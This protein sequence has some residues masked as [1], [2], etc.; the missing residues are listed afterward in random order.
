MKMNT[1][2]SLLSCAL[3]AMTFISF[4]S[5]SSDVI[6][7]S[8]VS[9][10]GQ[11]KV[12]FGF[13]KNAET[14]GL[15]ASTA[16]PT[17]SWGKN[18]KQLMILFVDNSSGQVKAARNITVP[19]EDNLDQKTTVLQNI[20]AGSFEA[21]LIANYNEANLKR[22][23]IAG[24]WNEGNVV[25]KNIN[26]LTLQLVTNDVFNPTSTESSTTAY[27]NPSEVF[28]AKQSVNVQADQSTTAPTFSL[29]RIIS[30]LRV[31][32]DQSQNGNNVVDFGHANADLRV[33]KVVNAFNPK[34]NF[35]GFAATNTIYSKGI[36]V[37]KKE[38]PS[39]GYKGGLILDQSNHITLWSDAYIFPGGSKTVGDQKLDIVLG[40]MAPEGYVPLGQTTGLR[41]PTMVYWSGQVQ[42]AVTSN[43]IL[44]V[45]CILKQAGSTE[46]PEIGSYGNLDLTINL[47]EW[48]NISSTN[49]EM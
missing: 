42:N 5:C 20:P 49:I 8:D 24:L 15:T 25:G 44:E 45:N 18:I 6:P 22:L 35:S 33:R 32:I 3:V 36:D 9:K 12:A 27:K 26:S 29:T 34:D 23:N 46:V 47:V 39:S 17:T 37:Y 48:G 13:D 30:I 21:Y 2:K 14:K 4:F 41:T 28:M 40:A 19:T 1:T 7:D 16:K 10:T 38:E 43:N 31:R 11:V